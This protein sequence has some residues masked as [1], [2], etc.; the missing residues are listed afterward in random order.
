MIEIF[1]ILNRLSNSLLSYKQNPLIYPVLP[2][3]YFFVFVCHL[4][5]VKYYLTCENILIFK[6]SSDSKWFWL[7]S[8]QSTNR[9]QNNF[10]S[11]YYSEYAINSSV[12]RLLKYD[13]FFFFF[14]YAECLKLLN[15]F[16]SFHVCSTC[17]LY[18]DGESS[19]WRQGLCA[20]FRWR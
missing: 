20:S 6:L 4:N 19:F 11:F 5:L 17:I 12:S 1:L 3:S 9:V 14:C 2:Y 8:A 16:S 7:P 10:G 18:Q 13:S 15:D